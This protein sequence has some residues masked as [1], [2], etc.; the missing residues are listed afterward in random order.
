MDIAKRH[1]RH[2]KT[3][4]LSSV[5]LPVERAI[6]NYQ[7]FEAFS[8]EDEARKSKMQQELAKLTKQYYDN[9]YAEYLEK[10]KSHII[11]YHLS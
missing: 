4:K 11:P 6:Q 10:R 3:I 7:D 9:G 5:L 1:Q 2:Y 8:I